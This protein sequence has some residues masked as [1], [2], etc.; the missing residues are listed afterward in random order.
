MTAPLRAQ[1]GGTVEG[2]V[3][4]SAT[5]AGIGGV[6]VTLWTQQGSSYQVTS[7]ESGAWR[8]TDM[9]PGQY[10]SRFEKSG[11]M[12]PPRA[13]PW[14]AS[15]L[16]VGAPG[17]PIRLDTALTPLA[18]LRGRVVD[19]EGRPAADVEV[20]LNAFQ[21]TRTDSEGQFALTGVK[22]GSYVLAA[23]AR[24]P[25]KPAA[26][27]NQ[28]VATYYPSAVQRSL[29]ATIVVHGGDE[30]SGFEIRLSA[31]PVF[32]MRGVV[33]DEFGKPVPEATVQLLTRQNE[34]TF[35]GQMMMGNL[36]YF[37][38]APREINEASIQ[39]NKQG[40]FEF[41]TVIPGDWLL[42]AESEP[43]RDLRQNLS[44]SWSADVPVT[45][46]DH[47]LDDLELRFAPTFTLQASLDWGDR[48]PPDTN[49]RGSGALFLV[50]LDN[51]QLNLPHFAEPGET[52]RFENIAA[53]RYRI[54]PLAGSPPGYYPASVTIAGQEVMGQPV[55]LSAA[56]PPLRITY[57]PNAG[58]VRGTVEKDDGATVLLWPQPSGALDMVRAVQANSV[59]AFEIGS[60]PPGDYFVLAVDRANLETQTEASLRSIMTAATRVTVD[61]NSVVNV[62][63]N[64]AHL[65][66]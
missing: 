42:R 19:P 65:P 7:D 13:I 3:V 59:G 45:L 17:N 12:E 58:T 47:D 15:A 24:P 49:R 64:V 21:T 40:A 1:T 14:P 44:L 2:R 66:E 39:S 30:L 32:R 50:S 28:I 46:S 43:K 11:F 5:G 34:T 27:H 56:T 31:S 33:L 55:E 26:E 4:N 10:D 51:R 18:T 38:G 20:G 25:K 36:R 6:A 23:K 53:G 48:P 16:R 63:L 57:R 8:V 61:E 52:L 37:I 60:I 54:I 22:P 29:A 9:K 62:P 35:A 41:A